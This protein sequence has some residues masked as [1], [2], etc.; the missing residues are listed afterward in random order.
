MNRLN[1]LELRKAAAMTGAAFVGAVGLTGCAVS[2]SNPDM[3]PQD[4]A[5]FEKILKPAAVKAARKVVA[6][7]DKDEKDQTELS[8]VS[9]DDGV[10]NGYEV[11]ITGLTSVGPMI[12]A[13]MKGFRKDGKLVL[14]PETV[15]YL[16]AED[17]YGDEFIS[18]TERGY[19]GVY[20]RQV[21]YTQ[22]FSELG[23]KAENPV[24]ATTHVDQPRN[25]QEINDSLDYAR[26]VASDFPD[27]IAGDLQLIRTAG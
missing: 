4:K 14:F 8:Y 24:L 3:K 27:E 22:G 16:D 26:E 7:V 6:F 25:E 17:Q 12:D 19:S 18:Q 15:Y 5:R 20:R 13:R 10:Q 23:P 2:L 1:S 9:R 11:Q 21:W